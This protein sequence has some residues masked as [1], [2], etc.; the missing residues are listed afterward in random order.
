MAEHYTP[1]EWAGYA[2][3][4]LATDQVASME[5]HLLQGCTSCGRELGFWQTL[6]TTLRQEREAVPS[7]RLDRALALV[8]SVARPLRGIVGARLMFD[9]FAMPLPSTVRGLQARRHCVYELDAEPAG[10]ASR[11]SLEVMIERL[12]RDQGWS[13]V[14]QVLNGKGEGWRD[15]VVELAGGE[16]GGAAPQTGRTNAW[17]EFSLA[18]A[19]AGSWS[20]GVQ[21]G[22]QRWGV[23]PL[24][25]P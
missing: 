15:C 14:G 23:A 25:M 1:Q 12:G 3:K 8:H 10:G 6:G 11:A 2:A 4:S 22:Q 19:G 17:G 16:T 13:V 18:P 9:S 7:Q 5:A 21:A 24:L 20:L